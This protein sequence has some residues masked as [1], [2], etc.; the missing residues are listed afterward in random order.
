M[1]V[2]MRSADLPADRID[3]V[4][5]LASV[6]EDTLDRLSDATQKAVDRLRA[7][8]STLML[9]RIQNSGSMRY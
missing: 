8:G 1:F 9:L 4:V 5:K 2:R 7:V 6:Q 3:D